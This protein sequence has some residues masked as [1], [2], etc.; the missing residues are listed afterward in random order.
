MSLLS[1]LV[2][3]GDLVG[4]MPPPHH[5]RG[6]AG[7]RAAALCQLWRKVYGSSRNT[8]VALCA[9]KRVSSKEGGSAVPDANNEGN[10]NNLQ[11]DLKFD[12]IS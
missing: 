12:V 3:Q 4:E 10:K 1:L 6:P 7:K 5:Q 11:D 2:R 9:L 8:A